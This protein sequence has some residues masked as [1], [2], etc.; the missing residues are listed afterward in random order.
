[1][2][3]FIEAGMP[4]DHPSLLKAG[5]YLVSH[6]TTTVGD[7]IVRSPDAEPGGWYFQFENE[8]YPDVDDS[9]VVLMA[10]AKVRM[11]QTSRVTRFHPTGA[12]LGSGHARV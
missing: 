3:A 7:W 8:L 11:A 4:Q 6:Q 1:M 2:N 5:A 12:E 9:A 10:L